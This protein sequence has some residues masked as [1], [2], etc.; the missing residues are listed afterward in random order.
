MENRIKQYVW[1]KDKRRR[2]GVCR[3]CGN[4][5]DF[6]CSKCHNKPTGTWKEEYFF[7]GICMKSTTSKKYVCSNCGE[8]VEQ[9]Q[10]ECPRCM[11]DMEV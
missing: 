5:S 7:R 11:A 1:N 2:R 4:T 6:I 9:K 10:K 3:Q 8:V